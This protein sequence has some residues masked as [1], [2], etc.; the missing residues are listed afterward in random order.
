MRQILSERNEK[1]GAYP[2]DFET[3][4]KIYQL[5]TR[6]ANNFKTGLTLMQFTLAADDVAEPFKEVLLNSLRR[7]DC[8]TQHGKKFLILLVEA[9]GLEAD[10]IKE[11]IFAR[12][13]K[14][15]A[16]KIL[17]ERAEIF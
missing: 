6:M 3:F 16:S 13:E 17:F 11:R 9:N 8:V 12:L 1:S 10:K 15:L 7:S 5:L 2:V 4:R 14:N